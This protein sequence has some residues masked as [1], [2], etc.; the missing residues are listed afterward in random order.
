[1]GVAIPLSLFPS[2]VTTLPKRRL[3]L[4][5]MTN[6]YKEMKLQRG[7]FKFY[8]IP[9]VPLSECCRYVY[10]NAYFNP[11]SFFW[12]IVLKRKNLKQGIEKIYTFVSSHL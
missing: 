7:A 10:K 9:L 1:M 11:V 4:G 12:Q 6:I 2:V 5:S 8:K 3:S